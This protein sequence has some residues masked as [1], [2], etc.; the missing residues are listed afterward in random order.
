MITYFL[1]KWYLFGTFHVY[2]G[3]APVIEYVINWSLGIGLITTICF[4][5][6][7]CFL[8]E[9][10]PSKENLLKLFVIAAL[11]FGFPLFIPVMVD[12]CLIIVALCIPVTIIKAVTFSLKM[13]NTSLDRKFEKYTREAY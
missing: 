12:V 7:F 3:Q 13:V 6:Y 1:V 8:N 2:Y 11:S 4:T 9:G 5:I 10:L